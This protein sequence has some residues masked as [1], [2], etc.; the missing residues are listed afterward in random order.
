MVLN[1]DAK[2]EVEG[3]RW[4]LTRRSVMGILFMALMVLASLRFAKYRTRAEENRRKLVQGSPGDGVHT[5]PP[6]TTRD[7]GHGVEEE[8]A[9]SGGG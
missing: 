1:S 4:V 7:S 5:G 2:S 6:R 3:L 9:A 8:L